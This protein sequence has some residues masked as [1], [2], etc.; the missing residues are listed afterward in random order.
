MATLD[1]APGSFDL[2]VSS[3]AM[4][5]LDDSRKRALCGSSARWLRPGGWFVLCDR[6]HTDAPH[7]TDLYRRLRREHAFARG[8]TEEEWQQWTRHEVEH[9]LPC[10]LAGPLA[11][12]RDAGFGTVDCVWRRYAW[13]TILA[14]TP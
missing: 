7:L 8:A 9:D 1:F 14:G 4:H 3:L 2:V 6:F 13:A 12:L 11:W 10:R 5:H